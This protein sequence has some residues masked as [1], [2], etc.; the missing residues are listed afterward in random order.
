MKPRKAVILLLLIPA[1][2]IV[3]TWSVP[4]R[5]R[6]LFFLCIGLQLAILIARCQDARWM[7]REAHAWS[8]RRGYRPRPTDAGQ[9]IDA[10]IAEIDKTTVGK[11]LA[12]RMRRTPGLHVVV[13]GDSAESHPASSDALYDPE[14]DG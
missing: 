5:S 9:W 7:D 2:L 11:L 6:I 13:R 4:S 12:S 1:C 10:P 3:F 8:L 14:L